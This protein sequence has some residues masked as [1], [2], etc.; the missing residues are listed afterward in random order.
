M[1]IG[2]TD[3]AGQTMTKVTRL[4]FSAL[5]A[6]VLPVPLIA[7]QVVE[8][9]VVIVVQNA[10][11]AR[12]AQTQEAIGFWNT[13]LAELDVAVRLRE[14]VLVVGSPAGRLIETFA[15][16][17]SQRGGRIP[18]GTSGPQPP[19]ALSELTGDVVVLLSRQPL[20]P[21]AWPLIGSPDYFVAIR[22]PE[23]RR[24]NDAIVLRNIIAH[25]LGHT[26]GLTHH[27]TSITLI[28]GPCSSVAAADNT[29]EWLPLTDV[30]RER[31]RAL[32][33]TP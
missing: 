24:P 19:S 18:K 10:D 22:A 32:H 5:V 7:G 4:A 29:L 17:V 31:L 14:S 26:L 11:D 27:R 23:P 1:A 25:E 9:Q 3:V 8:R 28:C 2:P 12:I 33:P 20:L 6:S 21:F 16:F 15:R 30:D 13:T